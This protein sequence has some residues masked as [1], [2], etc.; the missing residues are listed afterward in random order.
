M[1]ASICASAHRDWGFPIV[2]FID[3]YHAQ[4]RWLRA[5]TVTRWHFK[6][7]YTHCEGGDAV[8]LRM[9]R[10]SDFIPPPILLYSIIK[11]RVF[12]ANQAVICLEL[13]SSFHLGKQ[14]PW[15]EAKVNSKIRNKEARWLGMWLARLLLIVSQRQLVF[16][17]SSHLSPFHT[18][19]RSKPLLSE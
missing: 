19:V 18:W 1:Q 12:R 15:Q 7:K 5:T 10:V 2:Y 9:K 11:I 3:K 13:E 16:F 14:L 8:F 6:F 4:I 17:L